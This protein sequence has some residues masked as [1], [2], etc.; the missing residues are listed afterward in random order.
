MLRSI[1]ATTAILFAS[2]SAMAFPSEQVWEAQITNNQR[3]CGVEYKNGYAKG[4]ILVKGEQG[5]DNGKA[6]VFKLK[7][8]TPQVTWKI[9]E[10]KLIENRTEFDFDENLMNIQ[11]KDK[12]SVYV[13]N[14]EYAWADT[15]QEQSVPKQT[16]IKLVP[17]INMEQQDLPYGTTTIQGKLVVTCTNIGSL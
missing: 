6:L 1:I 9:T 7:A 16:E 2:A 3:V 13:N 17:K 12:T 4:G 14:K 10:A 8:N 11:T 15:K 5:T